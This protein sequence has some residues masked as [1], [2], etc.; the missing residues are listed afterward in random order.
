MQLNIFNKNTLPRCKEVIKEAEAV[1]AKCMSLKMAVSK[2]EEL[3]S[4]HTSLKRKMEESSYSPITLVAEC[5][6]FHIPRKYISSSITLKDMLEDHP[7]DEVELLLD[8]SKRTLEEVLNLMVYPYIKNINPE[9]C[10]QIYALASYLFMPDILKLCQHEIEQ[11]LSLFDF[12]EKMP[13]S[14]SKKGIF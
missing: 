12:S 10:R 5:A 2:M 7:D 4:R 9:N 8:C 3:L 6:S 13:R 1:I 14:L 11:G